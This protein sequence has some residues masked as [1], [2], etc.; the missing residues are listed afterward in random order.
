MGYRVW[1]SSP[2]DREQLVAEIFFGDQQ[3]AEN[4]QQR[5]TLEVEFYPRVD[6]EPWLVAYDA[7]LRALEDGKRRLVGDGSRPVG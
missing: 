6:R 7:A 5:G 2:P 4:N 1:I 3:W